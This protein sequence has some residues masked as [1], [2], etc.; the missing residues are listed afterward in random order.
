M[1]YSM[2]VSEKMCHEDLRTEKISKICRTNQKLWCS[3]FLI[4][5]IF[6]NKMAGNSKFNV[7]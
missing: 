3:E 1:V 7:L 4:C 5:S 6:S 2:T